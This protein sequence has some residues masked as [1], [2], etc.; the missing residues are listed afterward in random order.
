MIEGY[1]FALLLP[2]I[3]LLKIP[4]PVLVLGCNPDVKP[5]FYFVPLAEPYAPDV[6]VRRVSSH[7]G[8]AT[9]EASEFGWFGQKFC[10]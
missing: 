3:L 1:S 5:D 4:F 9:L 6:Q 8:L 10:P 2:E 7:G